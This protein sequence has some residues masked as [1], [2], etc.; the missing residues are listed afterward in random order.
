[1][2]CMLR[3][4]SSEEIWAIA[5]VGDD[6]KVSGSGQGK[7]TG[8][9]GVGLGMCCETLEESEESESEEKREELVREWNKPAEVWDYILS[10][11]CS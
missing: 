7:T 1:M 10:C 6:T 9:Y 11:R 4:T 3:T 5:V 8:M 2:M